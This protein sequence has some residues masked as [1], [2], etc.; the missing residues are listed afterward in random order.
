MGKHGF[1]IIDAD[2]QHDPAWIPRMVSLLGTYELVVGARAGLLRQP[3][4]RLVVA[5]NQADGRLLEIGDDGSV[6][7]QLA[8]M[9]QELVKQ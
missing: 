8:Q 5:Q 2:G 9:R 4:G 1:H 6:K 3:D 7:T